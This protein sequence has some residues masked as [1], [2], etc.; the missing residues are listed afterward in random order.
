M[1][2]LNKY[3]SKKL[4]YSDRQNFQSL[5]K[6]SLFEHE[7]CNP[8]LLDLYGNKWTLNKSKKKFLKA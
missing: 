1:G 8:K 5:P 7:T 2:Y 6:Y 4:L 3:K